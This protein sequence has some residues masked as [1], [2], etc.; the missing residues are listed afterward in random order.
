MPKG[1]APQGD[2]AVNDT[3]KKTA[4]QVDMQE[5]TA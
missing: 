5:H 2:Q 4:L 1:H 3:F